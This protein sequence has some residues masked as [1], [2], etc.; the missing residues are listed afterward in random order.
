MA[1]IIFT[2]EYLEV[3]EQYEKRFGREF[4][5]I[6]YDTDESIEIMRECLKTGKAY[7]LL[8][9]PNFDPDAVY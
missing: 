1:E 5:G 4:D 7:D 9:D 8:S 3:S 6:P 2:P